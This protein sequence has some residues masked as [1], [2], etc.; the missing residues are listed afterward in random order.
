MLSA[1]YQAFPWIVVSK[2]FASAYWVEPTHHRI[3][4]QYL[5]M[6]KDHSAVPD[7]RT[8]RAEGMVGS[9]AR[10]PGFVHSWS[11]STAWGGSPTTHKTCPPRGHTPYTWSP[12]SLSAHAGCSLPPALTPSPTAPPSLG[13]VPSQPSSGCCPSLL[14]GMELQ[15]L[16]TLLPSAPLYAVPDVWFC[17]SED[18]WIN[19]TFHC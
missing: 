18:K 15:P 6:L 14:A 9:G 1:R 4:P 19:K 11:G 2:L 10:P 3:I 5:W 17:S 13:T 12:A 16:T 8:A 7:H